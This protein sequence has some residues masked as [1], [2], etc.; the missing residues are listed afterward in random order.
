MKQNINIFDD[1]G[2]FQTKKRKSTKNLKTK[3][4]SFSELDYDDNFSSNKK[5][6]NVDYKKY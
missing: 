3:R 6:K 4:V 1:F 5:Y 2:E